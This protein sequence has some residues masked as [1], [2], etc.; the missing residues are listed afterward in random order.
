M[1]SANLFNQA[2]Y[3]ARAALGALSE[4]IANQ[5][6]Y[7]R[8]NNCVLL[9]KVHHFV[10]DER[11]LTISVESHWREFDSQGKKIIFENIHVPLSNLTH[12]LSGKLPDFP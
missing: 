2:G 1:H 4:S 5:V 11:G 10:L 12:I 8:S 7:E 9:V 3:A 6:I